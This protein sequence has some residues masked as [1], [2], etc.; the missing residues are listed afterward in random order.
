[1]DCFNFAKV[2]LPPLFRGASLAWEAENIPDQPAQDNACEGR[3]E[4]SY[5]PGL[6]KNP[7]Q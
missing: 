4:I 2:S 7:E 3:K 5:T 1:M 6:R